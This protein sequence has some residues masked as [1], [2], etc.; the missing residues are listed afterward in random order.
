MPGSDKSPAN[1]SNKG[2]PNHNYPLNCMPEFRPYSDL[3]TDAD[4]L[5]RRLIDAHPDVL[6]I[7]ILPKGSLALKR[8][9]ELEINQFSDLE[10]ADFVFS[11]LA[12][13]G[14]I[15]GFICAKKVTLMWQ[16]Q[17]TLAAGGEAVV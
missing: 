6:A 16:D 13:R 12:D 17:V 8:D 11:D 9:Y 3:P 2:F 1:P 5:L 14:K 10:W 15:R 4:P 7:A